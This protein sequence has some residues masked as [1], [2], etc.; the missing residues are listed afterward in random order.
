MELTKNY[1]NKKCHGFEAPLPLWPSGDLENEAIHSYFY[2]PHI[3]IAQI[4]LVGQSAEAAAVTH[5]N[6]RCKP[7]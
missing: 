4:E 3:F 5:T 2:L 7:M 1:C 6:N